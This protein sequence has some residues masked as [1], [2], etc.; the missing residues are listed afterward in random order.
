LQEGSLAESARRLEA[1]L[2][3]L[4]ARHPLLADSLRRTPADPRLAFETARD[5]TEI[6]AV[7]SSGA[8]LPLHSRYD[9]LLE[10]RKLAESLRGCGCGVVFGLGGGFHVEAMLDDHSLQVLLVVEKDASVLRSLFEHLD[11]SRLLA[12]PRVT[13]VCGPQAIPT[14]LASAWKPA[15]AGGM[16]AAPLRAW[17]D[18]EPEFFRSATDLLHSAVESVRADYSV[19]SHFGKRWLVNILRNLPLLRPAP[20]PWPAGSASQS[21]SRSA[22]VTG[23]GPSLDVQ[24]ELLTAGRPGSILVAT[25]TSLPALLGRGIQPDAVISIDC[26][27]YG[28][29]HFLAGLPRQTALYLDLASPPAVARQHSAPVFIGSGHPLVRYVD[30]HWIRLPRVDTSGG[31]VTHAAV[32]LAHALGA[33]DITVYGA[34]FAYP[35]LKAYARGTYLYDFFRSR[36]D[37]LA[38][39]ES[40][41]LSFALAN[42]IR[43]SRQGVTLPTTPLLLEYR[44]RFLRLMETI[45]ARVVSTQGLG[46]P[47][48]T[49]PTEAAGDT[50]AAGATKV[51][52]T[53]SWPPGATAPAPEW[54]QFLADYRGKVE[55]LP[56]RCLTPA[57]LEIRDTLLPV[58]ARVVKEG[59]PPGSAALDE[60]RRWTL[61]RIDR[62]LGSPG[63]R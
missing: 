56:A 20:A 39:A 30:A 41:L 10:G 16:K 48:V 18:Q 38:P 34:D 46:F 35:L 4:A 55:G 33:R 45:A 42:V 17:C 53:D 3:L 7:R 21:A 37:R 15:L 29:H 54:S 25:D 60:A 57:D 31:N 50:G 62:A 6:P 32:S 2:A 23:A 59:T 51:E 44:D 19:Q 9:P 63:P 58:A 24:M 28:Y 52:A 14:A 11:F 49:A 5:G 27:L 43:A 36:E 13:L 26:Q 8:A 22:A 12:D 47:L 61:E 40:S 1:N